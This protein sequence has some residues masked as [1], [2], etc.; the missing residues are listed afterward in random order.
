MCVYKMKSARKMNP[1]A[2]TYDNLSM[3]YLEGKSTPEEAL[4][5]LSWISESETHQERFESFKTVWELTD[6]DM[7]ETIDVDAALNAVNLKIDEVESHSTLTIEMPWLR[8]NLKYVSSVAAAVVVALFLGFLVLKPMTSTVTLASADWNSES[9]YLLPD[10]TAVKFGGTSEITYPKQFGK[11]LRSVDFEGTAHFDVSKDAERPFVIHCG[12]MDVEV[13]GTSF[14]LNADAEA[15][16]YKLD[17]YSGSVRMSVVDKKGRVLN[18]MEVEPGERG[19]CDLT[20]GTLKTM[21]YSEVKYDELTNDHVLDFNDVSLSVIVEA[22]EYI[23]NIK[24]DLAD[25]LA[26]VKMTARFTDEDSVDE[27]IETIA[28]VFDLKVTK[29][30]KGKYALR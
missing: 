5:L 29:S 26:D 11:N 17:L 3:S 6:F 18:A 28:T 27:V 20:D 9:P 16:Q 25:Q 2:P 30:G 7:P 1:N 24:I 13:L 4:A 21:S 14:L 12:N 8:R 10:G 15:N 23:F 22:L 19:V